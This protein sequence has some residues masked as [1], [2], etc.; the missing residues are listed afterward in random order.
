MLVV[1]FHN[2]DVLRIH[3]VQHN[4]MILDIRSMDMID[5]TLL[6]SVLRILSKNSTK[7]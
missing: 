4:L 2:K 5:L 7:S 6:C 1:G 3:L